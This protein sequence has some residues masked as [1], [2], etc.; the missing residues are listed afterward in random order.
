MIII[1]NVILTY[2]E[3]SALAANNYCTS[4]SGVFLKAQFVVP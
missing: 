2:A 3:S 1:D 4:S